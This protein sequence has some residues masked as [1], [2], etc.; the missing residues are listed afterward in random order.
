MHSAKKAFSTFSKTTKAERINYLEKLHDAVMN[1]VEEITAAT[2]EEYGAPV[3]RAIWSNRIAADSFLHFKTVLENFEFEKIVGKS[4]VILEPVGV[5]AILTSWNAN[6]GSI[7]VKLA[8]A[9]AAG[10]T[11]IIK[12]SELSA[13]QTQILAEAFHEAGLPNGVINIVNGRGEIVGKELSRNKDVVKVAFTGSTNVGKIVAREAIETMKRVTLELSGKSPNIILNDADFSVAIPQAVSFAFMN[14]GQACIAGSRLLVPEERLAEVKEL[15]IRAVK[16]IVVGDP[17]DEKTT[18]GPIVSKKQYE[19]VEKYIRAGIDEGAEVIIGGLGHPEGLEKGNFVKPTVFAGVTNDM[20]IAREEIF[21]PV[22]SILTFRTEEEAVE[23]AND[24]DYGLLAYVSSS[25]LAHANRIA[26]LL[27][28]G[29]VVINAFSHDPYTPF[30]G[31][32][33]S[34]IGREGGIFGLE[35]YLEP[36]AILVGV[37]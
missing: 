33:Q 16:K 36:K 34:G 8:A 35:E 19:Q 13:W 30:G 31:F 37:I 26:L 18:L 22:L 2:I 11:A 6:A 24:S 20:K 10:C 32:K 28:A 12:P 1:R 21:G 4:N 14:N 5:T 25:E 27:A 15:I 9:I 7:C 17:K 23:I 3:Q 29:R